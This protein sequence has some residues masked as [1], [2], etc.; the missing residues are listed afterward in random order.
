MPPQGRITVTR[1]S[2]DDVGFREIYV[3]LDGKRMAM[4]ESGQSV[5]CVV[6]AGR[7]RCRAHNTLFSKTHE[8]ELGSGEHKRFR[9]VNRAGWGTFSLLFVLGAGILYLTFEPEEER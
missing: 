7:H 5:T 2:A 4:L 8:F 6:D 9:A 3:S 1:S